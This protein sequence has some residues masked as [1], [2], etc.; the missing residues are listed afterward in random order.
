MLKMK[1]NEN[2][3]SGCPG[4]HHP[5]NDSD[6]FLSSGTAFGNSPFLPQKHHFALTPHS[7]LQARYHLYNQHLSRHSVSPTKYGFFTT[8]R[9]MQFPCH[10]AESD[11]AARQPGA[12]SDLLIQSHLPD[13]AAL[14]AFGPRCV[15]CVPNVSSRAGASVGPDC[16]SGSRREVAAVFCVLC[17]P[18]KYHISNY[19]LSRKP[20]CDGG[21]GYELSFVRC[22]CLFSHNIFRCNPLIHCYSKDH[23]NPSLF[24]FRPR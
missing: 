7:H 14:F 21:G 22:V 6:Y 10:R 13:H 4:P 24:T 19:G 5:I 9:V 17:N 3:I 1:I 15:G 16:L 8:C 12:G 20:L 2:E 18:C 23:N 11:T